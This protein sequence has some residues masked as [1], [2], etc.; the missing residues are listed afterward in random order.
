[1]NL[2]VFFLFTTPNIFILGVW[3][4]FRVL[5]MTALHQFHHKPLNNNEKVIN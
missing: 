2:S 4:S 5:L 3:G 1:M